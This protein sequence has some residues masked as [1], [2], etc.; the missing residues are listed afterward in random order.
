ML[1]RESFSH[2]APLS[3]AP[4]ILPPVSLPGHRGSLFF[5]AVIFESEVVYK[6]F[7]GLNEL[8]NNL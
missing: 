3:G 6:Y 7:L 2:P 8:S 1:G 5:L 4:G